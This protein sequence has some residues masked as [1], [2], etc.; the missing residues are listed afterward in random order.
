MKENMK[1]RLAVFLCILF[2]LPAIMAVLPQTAQEVQAA[3]WYLNWTIASSGN[4]GVLIAEK[5]AAFYI[6]D[7]ATVQNGSVTM[8][9]TVSM[10]KASY[11]TNKENIAAVNSEGYVEARETGKANITIKYKGKTLICTLTVVEAG[12][13]GTN[14]AYTKLAQAADTIAKNMPEKITTKNGFQLVK[15]FNKYEEVAES[16][17]QD[18]TDDG[19]IVDKESGSNFDATDNLVVPNASRYNRLYWE[20]RLY[21][22]KYSP[23][24]TKSS[25]VLKISSI[26]ATAGKVAINLKK[27]PSKEQI[28]ALKIDSSWYLEKRNLSAGNNQVYFYMNFCDKNNK[29]YLGLACMKKGSRTITVIP[30]KSYSRKSKNTKLKKNR[31][32][33]LDTEIHWMK[34]KSFTVR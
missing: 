31:T 22:E 7:Y 26:N 19:F 14:N 29:Y 9:G 18:I 24:S 34:G 2:V 11:S 21:A 16:V 17:K 12:S 32:Y 1:K 28:L 3:S 13:L 6:G 23:L 8:L 10:V 4:K 15:I 30:Q 5:G 20:L 33:Q 25:K 27:S